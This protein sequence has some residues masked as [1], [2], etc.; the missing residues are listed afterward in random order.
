[1]FFRFPQI[2]TNFAH[3]L[4]YIMSIF[5]KTIPL[6]TEL[7]ESESSFYSNL[8]GK[9]K[10]KF[11]YRLHRFIN[12]KTFSTR[13]GLELTERM[14]MLISAS[15][16]QLTFGLNDYHLDRFGTIIIY[17]K[18]FLSASDNLYHKGETNT[19]GAV[20]FSW[21]DFE[22]G[23]ANLEDKLNLGL[24]EWSHALMLNNFFESTQ[25]VS[26]VDYYRHW[27]IESND[28]YLNAGKEGSIFREYGGVNSAEFF[29][30]SVEVFFE[31]TREF[32]EQAPR[33]FK[34]MCIMLNQYP[35]GDLRKHA[36]EVEGV[37]Q[38]FIPTPESKVLGGRDS[39]SKFYDYS[40]WILSAALPAAVVFT[41]LHTGDKINAF[42]GLGTFAGF[43]WMEP[44]GYLLKKYFPGNS[45]YLSRDR[46]SLV[47]RENKIKKE[48]FFEDLAAVG[49]DAVGSKGTRYY[50]S[51]KYPEDHR[52][53]TERI[54]V[55]VDYKLTDEILQ[56]AKNWNLYIT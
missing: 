24:H 21:E 23:Y 12:A 16:I 8:E 33:L 32:S 13:E 49:I 38:P 39:I 43:I 52:L 40:F 3:I 20:V 14:K 30:V 34:F 17:P 35:M 56:A 54:P 4:I 53:V 36:F 31:A 46:I 2:N 15:A 22:D 50:V 10:E 51:V 55:H 5:E 19:H 44:L 37:E 9:E 11:E 1:M 27:A 6:D 42:V 26:F 28:E 29:A 47:N 45:L 18:A 48:Y 41:F 7:L 25:D